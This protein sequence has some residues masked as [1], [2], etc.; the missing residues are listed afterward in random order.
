[1][2]PTL[3]FHAL[4]LVALVWLFLMLY[5]LGPDN[6]AAGAPSRSQPR[7][8]RQR[9]NE[10]TPFAG[11]TQQPHC[12]LCEQDSMHPQASPPAPPEPLPPTHRRPHTVATARHCCPRAGCRYRGWL[13][14]G[15]LRANGHPRGGPW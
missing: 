12:A 11:L 4:V 9:S 7:L 1:M 5:W 3:F 10:P 14:R 2:V 6:P 8:P 15:N 13:G